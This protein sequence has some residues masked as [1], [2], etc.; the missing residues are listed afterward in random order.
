LRAQPSLD[1]IGQVD[2]VV[3]SHNHY[4]HLDKKTIQ[5]L[6][7]RYPHILYIV[8]QGVKKWFLNHIAS[9]QKKQVVELHWWN[10]FDWE[11]LRFTSVPAQHF[12]GRGL[13]DQDRSLWMGCVIE[14]AAG[15][16]VYF[17]GDTGYNAIDFKEIGTRFGGMDLSL[18]P[19]GVYTP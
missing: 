14:Y 19:I 2:C 18:L 17:A 9:I 1:Q 3:I 16:K 10:I 7:A 12:S 11:H 4:D 15:K 13:F 6:H 8:P 5:A